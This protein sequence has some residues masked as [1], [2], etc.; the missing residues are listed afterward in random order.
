MVAEILSEIDDCIFVVQDEMDRRQS[1]YIVPSTSIADLMARAF[2]DEGE[3]KILFYKGGMTISF[4]RQGN[5]PGVVLSLW[6]AWGRGKDAIR[7]IQSAIGGKI[8]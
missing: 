3:V 1:V 6:G 7:D 8:Y 4:Q 2:A 5:V